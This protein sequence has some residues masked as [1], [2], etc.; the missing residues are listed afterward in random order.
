LKTQTSIRRVVAVLGT[1][2]QR[3]SAISSWHKLLLILCGMA[4][5]V[6]AAQSGDFTYT[7]NG[8]A[9]TL[10]GYTGPGGDVSIPDV[11]NNQP[12]TAIAAKAFQNKP[13]LTGVTIPA[14]VT[15]IVTSAFSIDSN[16]TAITVDGFNTVY[17]SVD[18]VLFNRSQTTLLKC[19]GGKSGSYTIPAGVTSIANS[20]FA[21]CTSLG[22]VTI[23]PS[24]TSIE[25]AAFSNCTGLTDVVLS[26]SLT[27]ITDHTFNACANLGSIVIPG[28]VTTIGS[29]AFLSCAK[30]ASVSFPAGLTQ[31]GNNAFQS[32]TGLS[33]ITLP[34]TLTSIGNLAFQNCTGLSAVMIPRNVTSIGDRAFSSC[35]RLAAIAVDALNPIYGSDNGILFSKDQATLIQY[36]AGKVGDYAIPVGVVS[37]T[38]YAF[39]FCGSLTSVTIPA[40]VTS[41]GSYAFLLCGGLTSARFMGNAPAMG[42]AV[43]N[44][45]ASGFTVEYY[46]NRTGF[47]APSWLG[48][49]VL[50]VGDPAPVLAVEQ[51]TGTGLVTNI[52]TVSFGASPTGVAVSLTFTIK[53]VGT[54]LLTGI[55]LTRDGSNAADFTISPT[56]VTSLV[57]GTSTTCVV[58]FTPSVLG[59]R[60][61]T[62]NIAS[63]DTTNNT[64]H[65]NLSGSGIVPPILPPAGITPGS[66]NIG[67]VWFIGDSITQSNADGDGSG[68]P[69]KSLYDLLVA[70][71]Y[72]FSY[73]GHYTASV[74]GLPA[75]GGTVET[76]LYQYHSGIS[77]SVIG[78]DVSGRT[79]M[80]QNLPAFWT[81]GRLATVK[82]NVILIMLGTNDVDQSI[83]LTNAPARLTTLVNTIYSQ[84]GV[85]T[86][87]I[88]LA[89]VPPNRTDYADPFN[90]TAFN[91]AV[92]GV[93][94]SLQALGRKVRFVDQ[95]T[96]L[97]NAYATNMG[98]D[99]LHTNAVGNATLALQ[100][101]NAIAALATPLSV[102]PTALEL[103]RIAKFGDYSYTVAAADAA[104]PDGDGCR[105][106]DEY[107]AG[108]DPNKYS[109][110]FKVLTTS[111]DGTSISVTAAGKA[112][113]T[114]TLQHRA[115]LVSGIWAD[116][117]S[118]G[119]L[120]ADG[121]VYLTDDSPTATAGFYRLRV[122][123][124]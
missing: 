123:A 40:S 99:N 45:T 13:G 106:I 26:S 87:S 2:I 103:W 86:P 98:G 75:S 115:S 118:V 119:P 36:P 113:R 1:V 27:S 109:D 65:F 10:T 11:I 47:S 120:G 57:A 64:L 34:A 43:F 38:A 32:C 29:S 39:Y 104:D 90:T 23:P 58:T 67:A 77:G 6:S 74:D 44:F 92:P 51:P 4:H 7:V 54:A 21:S 17:S 107:I 60:V 93:V 71:G 91:A 55:A 25:A 50:N 53:N 121:T 78:S 105:N 3:F 102:P 101:F 62:L 61:A 28:N 100:W 82:P 81:S 88:F 114:Y 22:S 16:L 112:S 124:P 96:P 72:T 73:T 37:V 117:K 89:S 110:S 108:T 76:N 80:T 63:N 18:G 94:S 56:P 41:I 24:V 68:S 95:F 15:S 42:A 66:K 46:S 20:A 116:I 19:P 12:V 70:N 48:Y 83:D 97:N 30:L 31:I 9:I 122:T 49:P 8:S 33:S 35:T 52:S 5:P 85:G 14:S 84:P 59:T 79:G 69:R 111:V